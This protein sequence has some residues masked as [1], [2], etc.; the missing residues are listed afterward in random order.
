LV[1]LRCRLDFDLPRLSGNGLGNRDSQQSIAQLSADDL[2]VDKLGKAGV[3]LE[4]ARY[5][6]RCID[7]KLAVR[8]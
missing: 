7:P 1:R 6:F 5:A 4:S 3:A 2:A 8:G